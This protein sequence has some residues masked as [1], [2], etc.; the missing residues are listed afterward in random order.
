[1]YATISWP[2]TN[3][4]LP[5]INHFSSDDGSGI[6]PKKSQTGLSWAGVHHELKDEEVRNEIFKVKVSARDLEVN[7]NIEI[8]RSL[9]TRI[10]KVSYLLSF[11]CK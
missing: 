10:F 2:D 3:R 8:N 5:D 9:M 6:D 1:L 11:P 4:H 7:K